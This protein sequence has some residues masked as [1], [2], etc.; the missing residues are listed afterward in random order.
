MDCQTWQLT[1][2]P[3]GRRAL[4][5]KWVF[6]RKLNADGTIER[7]KARLVIR[8]FE[9][10]A[11]V[12]FFAVFAP[13]A[14]RSTVRLFFSV[15]ASRDLECHAIDIS[16]AFVQSE[17]SDGE[18]YMQQPPG[19]DDGS[20]M[21]CH[22]HKSLYG[23]K[24]APRLWHQLLAQFLLD[25][26][27]VRS[28]SDAAVFFLRRHGEPTVFLL[29]YVDDIQ[30][31]CSAISTIVAV[32]RA[33]LHR[34]PGKD[35]GETTYFLQMSIRRDRSRR[36]LVF[37]QQRH[38]DALVSE[39]GLG[40]AN[41]KKL[42]MISKVYADALGPPV[43]DPGALRQYRAVLGV[44]NYL[45]CHTR[46]DIAFAVGYLSRFQQAPT[47][48]KVARVRDVVLYLKGTAHFG[49][50]LGGSSVLRAFCDA[51]FA[52]C[53]TTRRSTT[54]LVLFCGSGPISW[55]SKRQ[56][57]VSRSTAEAEY[58]AAGETAKE[59]QYMYELARQFELSP[60]CV[61][62]FTDN[63]AALA[64]CSDPLSHDRSKH[65]DVI[66]HHVRERVQCGEI[67]FVQ[68][69]SQDN[70]ADVFTKPLALES[71]ATFRLALGVSA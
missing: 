58:I 65:I 23:L 5:C 9:Q 31:A 70:V 30:I 53:P 51:D 55:R 26:G 56:P 63:A 6:K 60:S 10:L 32:K 71:L 48:D 52:Q 27:F 69:P 61:Q 64:L 34:F 20:G 3:H 62:C 19:F 25:F 40:S 46:P 54:G 35:L 18:I 57:T 2:L 22:L 67:R 11:G 8:G 45:A 28:P 47:A 50:H 44:L 59:V 13:V 43:T 36:M 33:L 29:M 37:S 68:I 12:D 1:P 15:V 38:V 49:L 7:Y 14:R 4:S 41:L 66:H 21:V 24:Q 39:L 42:P 17:L 16:N